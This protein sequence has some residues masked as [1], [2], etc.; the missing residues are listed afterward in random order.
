MNY[1]NIG[2]IIGISIAGCIVWNSLLLGGYHWYKAIN[3][4]RGQQWTVTKSLGHEPAELAM[5]MEFDSLKQLEKAIKEELK[6]RE[7][8]KK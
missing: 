3:E 6:Y 5:D 4:W 8:T 2:K 1:W 7:N